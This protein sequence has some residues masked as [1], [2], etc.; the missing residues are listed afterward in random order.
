MGIFCLIITVLIYIDEIINL[1]FL[2]L[3]FAGTVE[4]E[5]TKMGNLIK[6]GSFVL[7]MFIFALAL[8]A[9]TLQTYLCWQV[10]AY[11]KEIVDGSMESQ[12]GEGQSDA[13]E[14]EHDVENQPVSN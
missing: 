1:L 12:E 3:V 8:F 2:I 13:K 9:L 14:Y 4:T 6:T 10:V 7:G 5:Q 11:H